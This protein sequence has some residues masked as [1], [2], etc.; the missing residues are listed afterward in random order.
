[1]FIIHRLAFNAVYDRQGHFLFEPLGRRE[2]L[3]LCHFCS[4]PESSRRSRLSRVK[5]RADWRRASIYGIGNGEQ[6]TTRKNKNCCGGLSRNQER[7][8]GDATGSDAL[9]K[10]LQPGLSSIR[11]HPEIFVILLVALQAQP[12]T[13]E[14]QPLAQAPAHGGQLPTSNRSLRYVQSYPKYF[15]RL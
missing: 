13:P 4:P 8:F 2:F 7:F 14:S 6:K 9:L 10:T 11:L 12:Q 1:M 3:G 5:R 15:P